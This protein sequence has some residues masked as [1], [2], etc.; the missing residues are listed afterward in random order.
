MNE[1]LNTIA[2]TPA[3]WKAF[4]DRNLPVQAPIQSLLTK[5]RPYY[6]P[7]GMTNERLYVLAPYL[8]G[9]ACL[10]IA[11]LKLSDAVVFGGTESLFMGAIPNLDAR[12]EEGLTPA[13]VRTFCYEWLGFSQQMA[14]T[15]FNQ[16]HVFGQGYMDTPEH[17]LEWYLDDFVV[18]HQLTGATTLS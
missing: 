11:S 6:H 7:D 1:E 16:T 2:N 12:L 5:W 14:R 9:M 3:L 8:D 17:Y 4:V 13:I 10:L 15:T 18:K